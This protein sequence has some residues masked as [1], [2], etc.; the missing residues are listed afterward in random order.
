MFSDL[1][2]ALRQ[3]AKSPGFTAIALITLALGI[4]VNTS[5]FSLMNL[6]VLKPLPYAESDS[7]ARI[8]R[9]HPQNSTAPHSAS[10]FLELARETEGF[11]QL[12]A[13]RTWGY[14]LT[15]DGRPPVN[16]NAARVSANFL[17]T[18][19]LK[20]QL[21]RW[22][23]AD[24]D[25]P[26]NQVIILSY[27]MWQAH[28]GG[29]PAVVGTT[30]RLDGQST[31]IVGVMPASFTSV[32]LWGPTDILR[33]LGLSVAEKE[34]LGEMAIDLLARRP[35]GVTLEQFNARLAT[36]ARQLKAIRPANRTED[37]LHAVSLESVARNPTTK[38]IS[39]LMLGLAGFVLLIACANLANLQLARAVARSHEFAI[40]SALGA[41]HARL[42]RPQLA[43]SL[44]LSLGGG[45]LGLLLAV[46]ANDW[47][48][49][50]V[51]AQGILHLHLSLDWRVLTFAMV[52]SAATAVL[53]GLAPAWR[54]SRVKGNDALKCATRGNTGDRTQ[55]RL[56]QSLI[57]SQFANALILLACAAGF[58]RGVDQLVNP[59][60]GWDQAKIV[61]A[62]IK[63]SDAK[64]STPEQAYAFHT[65]LEEQL[66][67]LP[68]VENATVAWTLPVFQYLSNR[69][70]IAQGQ[71]PPPAGHEPVTYINGVSPSYLATLGI[72]LQAGRNFTAGDTLNSVPVAIINASF[73][74]T[75]FP[76]EN[77]VGRRIGNPDPSNPGWIEIVGVVP[78]VERAVG[79]VP[80][81]SRFLV[82][83]PLAQ[84]PWTYV[85]AAIRTSNPAALV[86]PMRQAIAALDS[87]LA[88][89]QFGTMQQ[90]TQLVTGSAR[91]LSKVL[92]CFAF[93][94]LFLAALG[95]YGVIARIVV[96][97]TPEIGVRIALGAQARDV[98]GMIL[99]FGLRMTLL[100]SAI[101]L[102]GAFGLGWAL[103][104][105]A[106]TPASSEPLLI[107][108]V[109]VGLIG[110]GLFACWIPA[111]RAARV[112]PM[113]ALR[114]E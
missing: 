30:V 81:T 8:Y 4:G 21:G 39:G 44:L 112:D 36:V 15:P 79:A 18:L 82:L 9:T 25:H 2:L 48:E 63:M 103:Q 104:K 100:G 50:A 13:W 85:A 73:A 89:Q 111:R 62:V 12:A 57:V 66:R 56:Q 105:F 37:G 80:S 71:P 101:G 70:M 51:S 1:R 31:T 58:M 55:N 20:P 83:R 49:S 35:T 92:V 93:L 108:A 67:A 84:E 32:F 106:P 65:R 76:G 74:Q 7:L 98:V 28:F 41:S 97:R 16:A 102:L 107:V 46:W 11:A 47:I 114:A 86:E 69:S 38:L 34:N 90:V 14:T 52:L 53:F 24:E 5:M 29:D 54:V 75:L 78:D 72:P 6:L 88:P 110:V 45:L 109:T 3:L 26:G 22:F 33:P 23:A 96:R 42:L 17:P 99:F 10:D 95:I 77:P 27:E 113:T 43:E 60:P 59:H 64:Y 40:R 91:L 87:E 94:G 19:G 68:G 61:Q